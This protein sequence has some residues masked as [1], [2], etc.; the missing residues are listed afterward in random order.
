MA[1]GSTVR[2]KELERS[3]SDGDVFDGRFYFLY[4]VCALKTPRSSV[5]L[6]RSVVKLLLI[7]TVKLMI[8][9]VEELFVQP[10]DGARR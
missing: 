5:G 9:G 1:L 10:A 8:R 2:L 4:V 6:I 3:C 7:S